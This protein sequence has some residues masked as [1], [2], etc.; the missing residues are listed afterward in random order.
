M[1]LVCIYLLSLACIV[2]LVYIYH[3]RKYVVYVNDIHYN[4]TKELL[5]LLTKDIP[6]KTFSSLQKVENDTAL[7]RRRPIRLYFPNRFISITEQNNNNNNNNNNTC[8]QL[9][10]IRAHDRV[11]NAFF[12]QLAD[13]IYCNFNHPKGYSMPPSILSIFDKPTRYTF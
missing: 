6:I 5:L 10:D 13:Y 1:I 11:S 12:K 8:L 2:N 9:H 7:D 4:D 3:E